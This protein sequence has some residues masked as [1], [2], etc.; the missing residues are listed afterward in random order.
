MTI[1]ERIWLFQPYHEIAADRL[2][3]LSDIWYGEENLADSD[4]QDG[5]KHEYV[6]VKEM[7]DHERGCQGREYTCTC[8]YDDK[9]EAEVTRLLSALSEA[10][11]E[12][13]RVKIAF[14][15]AFE[16]LC[17]QLTLANDMRTRAEKVETEFA[18]ARKALTPSAETKAAYMGEFSISFPDWDH[19]GDEITRRINVPWVTIKEIMA[20]ISARALITDT[21]EGQP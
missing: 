11:K 6:R 4:I 16:E 1:P 7:N 14:S 18:Q 15:T 21:K 5:V 13:D 10:E 20:A 3:G 2:C 8:G 19:N 17:E 9:R 12:R